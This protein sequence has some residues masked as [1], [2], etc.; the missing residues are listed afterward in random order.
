[1]P[2]QAESRK[3]IHVAPTN[4]TASAATLGGG[5][6][7]GKAAFRVLTLKLSDVVDQMPAEQA[8]DEGK[9]TRGR[10]D[11]AYTK[12]TRPIEKNEVSRSCFRAEPVH[13]SGMCCAA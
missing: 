10:F 11:K 6:N 13:T 9:D 8:N 3:G 12:A 1:M 2:W 5:W 7:P 4:A